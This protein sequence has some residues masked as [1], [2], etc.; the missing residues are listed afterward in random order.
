MKTYTVQTICSNCGESQ[1]VELPQ[2]VRFA[3][4]YAKCK[5]CGCSSLA[6]IKTEKIK[7]EALY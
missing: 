6:Q 4:S 7:R 5:N 3:D 2:G 1:S